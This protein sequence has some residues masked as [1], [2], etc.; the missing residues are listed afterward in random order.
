[1]ITLEATHLTRFYGQHQ[2]LHDI[3]FTLEGA[4]VTGLL[5]R[6]GAGKSTLLRLL[7]AQDIPTRGEVRSGSVSTTSDPLTWRAMIGWLPEAPPLHG[8]E[9]PTSMLAYHLGLH[10]IHG[11]QATTTID[12]FI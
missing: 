10:G 2:V 6:N 5:G 7:A 8:D 11:K 9:T 3:S 12:E 4:G 1:M